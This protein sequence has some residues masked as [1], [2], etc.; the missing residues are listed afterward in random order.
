MI[1]VNHEELINNAAPAVF[2]LS[3][4]SDKIHVVRAE[5]RWPRSSPLNRSISSS[6]KK[7]RERE[8]YLEVEGAIYTRLH[9]SL[10]RVIGIARSCSA[11]CSSGAHL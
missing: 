2:P 9:V 11:V 5:L 10:I 7:K 3:S 1:I 8:T 4:M 6:A